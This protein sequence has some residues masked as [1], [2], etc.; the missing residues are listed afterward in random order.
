MV[1]AV[2][3]RRRRQDAKRLVHGLVV[4]DRDVSK[5]LVGPVMAHLPVGVAA[6]ACQ[7]HCWLLP[8]LLAA[9]LGRLRLARLRPLLVDGASGDLLGAVLGSTRLALA[10]LDVLVLPF[11]LGR[12]CALWHDSLLSSNV[13]SNDGQPPGPW[14][15]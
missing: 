7:A 9:R 10:L 4:L 15:V 3:R 12:P 6:P 5:V 1:A 8:E 14:P 11:T 13:V 2:A